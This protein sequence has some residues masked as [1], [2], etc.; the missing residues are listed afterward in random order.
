MAGL[1]L[2]AGLMY[3]PL[4]KMLRPRA[5]G[6]SGAQRAKLRNNACQLIWSQQRRHEAGYA[7]HGQ[8][9]ACKAG[10]GTA[11]H[12]IWKCDHTQTE[13]RQQGHSPEMDAT[14]ETDE[15]HP[16]WSFGLFPLPGAYW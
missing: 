7:S 2:E 14:R 3:E 10:Q 1:S 8:C 5:G 12:W 4:A 9:P 13:R 11:R 15:E 16:A 6:L